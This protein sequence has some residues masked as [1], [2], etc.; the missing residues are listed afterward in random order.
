MKM[1][2]PNLA[3]DR[4]YTHTTIIQFL[5]KFIEQ[6]NGLIEILKLVGETESR[7]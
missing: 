4:D 5:H 6:E 1:V 3:F 7:D 2:N